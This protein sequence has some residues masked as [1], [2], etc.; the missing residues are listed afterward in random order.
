MSSTGPAEFRSSREKKVL[1]VPADIP[2]KWLQTK[3]RPTF[4]GPCYDDIWSIFAEEFLPTTDP[5]DGNNDKSDE[6]DDRF[7]GMIVTGTPGC[8]KWCFLDFCLHQLRSLG[9]SVLY[10]H[11]KSGK[12]FVYSSDNSLAEYQINDAIFGGI[13]D[14]VDFLLLDPPEGGDP[15]FF[16]LDNM[17]GK[18]FILTVPPDAD[19]CKSTPKDA[20]YLQV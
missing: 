19:N 9:R 4:V 8:G 10:V 17:K 20:H 6:D 3:S 1:R 16:G 15:N 7:D 12:A 14:Q 5:D 11:G 18:P 13:A 2:R